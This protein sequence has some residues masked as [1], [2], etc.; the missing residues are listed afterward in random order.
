M[1]TFLLLI[2]LSV[3]S[4]AAVDVAALAT[5]GNG[6]QAAPWTGWEALTPAANTEYHFRSGWFAFN[7]SP[8]F[9]KPGLAL[10]GESGTYLLH[11]GAGNGLSFI[12]QLSFTDNVRAENFTLLGN[13]ATTNA[14][15]VRGL[16]GSNFRN[17]QIGNCAKA[18]VWIEAGII[19]VW[20]NVK[21]SKYEVPNYGAF[22]PIP[23]YGYVL[24][25]RYAD[26]G[27][28]LGGGT[29]TQTFINPICEGISGIGF[30]LQGG[31][32]GCSV[33]NGTFEE[34]SGLGM[35][36]EGTLTT[37]QSTDF[38]ANILGD[39][40][41]RG[42]QNLLLNIFSSV[43]VKIKAGQHQKIHGGRLHDL[44]I[45]FTC[46][47]PQVI[48]TTVLGAFDDGS[49]STV[50]F[51]NNIAGVG[52]TKTAQIGAVLPQIINGTIVSGVLNTDASKGDLVKAVV[53]QN[54]TLA[55]PTNGVD[56]QK[57]TWRITVQAGGWQI[58]YG[59]KFRPMKGLYPAL[60]LG[61]TWVYLTA[62]YNAAQ[63]TWDIVDFSY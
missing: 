32:Y 40:E 33:I 15:F 35:K 13:A 41:M 45:D 16:R 12:N 50:K 59:D 62:R 20:D 9:S 57:V 43:S 28:M 23:Q 21:V 14:L 22:F 55:N 52:F 31:S 4:F 51:G 47:Q 26:E 7:Q 11:T 27:S 61:V 53:A 36:L 29:T 46:D 2:L 17:I 1:K 38:E 25:S 60:P 48:G 44:S 24:A 54:F 18:G 58:A 42:Y 19:N 6:T 8:N 5:S 63:Q 37:I 10:T 56:G 34:N 49:A 39:V 3:P 30:W